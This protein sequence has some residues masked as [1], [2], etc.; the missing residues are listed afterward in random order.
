MNANRIRV[1]LVG[2]NWGLTHIAA[3]QSIPGIE[4]AAI[5]TSRQESAD[6]VAA[7]H[8]IPAAYGDAAAM[9]ADTTLDLIDVTTRPSIRAPIALASLQ[10][11]RHL[12]QPLPFAMDLAQGR[13]LRDLARSGD[14]LAMVE[15]LHLHSP[16]F[17]QAKAMI[18]QGEIGELRSVRAHVRTNI[19]LDL[20]PG[21]A[22]LWTVDPSSGASALRNFGAHALHV[23]KWMIGDVDA[24]A[25]ML[26]INLPE[27]VRPDGPPVKTGTYDSGALLLAFANGVDGMLDVSWSMPGMNE[28]AIDIGGSKG[29]VIVK[30]DGLGPRNPSLYFTNQARSAAQQIPIDPAFRA[31]ST[32]AS[33]DDTLE[34]LAFWCKAAAEAIASGDRS[35]AVPNFDT[36]LEMMEIVEAAYQAHRERRWVR[37]ADFR[38]A[39]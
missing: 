7:E 3:W 12:I 19:L 4:L 14:R 39:A 36:A 33:Q 2:A 1:G 37:L 15:N 16:A 26:K 13:K 5:C 28:I 18:D 25:A 20:P 27:V 11:G 9:L 8:G 10:A 17:R 29:R 21:F 31:G 24:V 6:R 32:V 38:A 35:G 30:A 23:L 22:Y 34:S